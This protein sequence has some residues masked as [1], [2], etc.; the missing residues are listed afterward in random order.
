MVLPVHNLCVTPN[1]PWYSCLIIKCKFITWQL[2][3]ANSTSRKKI[4]SKVLNSPICCSEGLQVVGTS[5]NRNSV[6][7]G[8]R[9][10][11]ESSSLRPYCNH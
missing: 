3:V 7:G 9:T 10:T 11:G 4:Q 1:N 6:Q 8:V 5:C 2:S